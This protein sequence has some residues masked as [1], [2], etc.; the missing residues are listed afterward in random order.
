MY[1]IYI[2]YSI[3]ICVCTPTPDFIWQPAS[4]AHIAKERLVPQLRQEQTD[5]SHAPV[6][7]C[8]V[9]NFPPRLFVSNQMTSIVAGERS[10]RATS[11]FRT[12]SDVIVP[13]ISQI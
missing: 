11:K 13:Q 1:N 8:W 9:A 6:V 4:A 2:Y 7:R 12:A 5:L 10:V 3:Y